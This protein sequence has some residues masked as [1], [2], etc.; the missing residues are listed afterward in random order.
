VGEYYWGYAS[1]VVTTK[2]EEWGEFVLAE[3]TQPF[4]KGDATYF[5]PLMKQ[6]EERL[7]QRPHFGALDAAYDAHYVYEYFRQAGGFAAVPLAKRGD[8]SRTF[9]EQGLP[10][11]KAGLSTPALAPQ[12]QVCRSRAHL[13][14]IRPPSSTS[15]GTMSVRCAPCGKGLRPV[16]QTKAPTLARRGNPRSSR[17]CR[18]PV[19]STISTGP[20]AAAW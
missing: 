4:D 3:L 6:V 2:V 1:G 14:V 8:T 10:L 5:F 7:G 11:C 13:S 9:D 18:Q 19:R 15:A 12:V 17:R 16:P 20:R